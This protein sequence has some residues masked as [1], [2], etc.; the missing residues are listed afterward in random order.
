MQFSPHNMAL[1]HF[2]QVRLHQKWLNPQAVQKW[3]T[4]VFIMACRHV[5]RCWQ[6]M[7][8]I[9]SNLSERQTCIAVLSTSRIRLGLMH[10]VRTVGTWLVTHASHTVPIGT[11]AWSP[12]ILKEYSMLKSLCTNVALDLERSNGMINQAKGI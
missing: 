7:K 6:Q 3:D 2:T 8:S 12:L 4:V 10:A 9:P 1:L 5:V 11:L